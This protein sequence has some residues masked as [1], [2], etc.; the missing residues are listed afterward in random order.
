MHKVLIKSREDCKYCTEAKHF[1]IGMEINFE[2][3]YSP[4]GKV[5]QI[6][7]GDNHIGGYKEL[8][9]LSQSQEWDKTFNG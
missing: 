9:E 6:Y 3:E 2:E 1:L 5:P 4:T 8:M 7:V